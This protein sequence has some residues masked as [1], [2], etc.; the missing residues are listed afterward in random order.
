MYLFISYV[1]FE[2]V[3]A[4]CSGTH[5]IRFYF[6]LLLALLLCF[7]T[8]CLMSAFCNCQAGKMDPY[9]ILICRT[10]EQRSSIASGACPVYA[11][12]LVYAVCTII[13]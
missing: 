6:S 12:L 1:I 13:Y 11:I 8:Q 4:F 9:A 2:K 5:M 3:I 7:Y 10:Q